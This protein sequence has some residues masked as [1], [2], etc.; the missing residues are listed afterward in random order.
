MIDSFNF[1]MEGIEALAKSIG[2][3]QAFLRA[4][5]RC[6]Y[7]RAMRMDKDLRWNA[8]ECPLIDEQR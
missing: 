6:K 8:A 7:R 5:R 2:T 1:D 3:T 4:Q